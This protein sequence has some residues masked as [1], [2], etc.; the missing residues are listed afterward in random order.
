MA[1]S[2]KENIDASL[3]AFCSLTQRPE[4]FI[5]VQK[6]AA[7]KFT[8]TL[9]N[10]YD[11]TK[12]TEASSVTSADTLPELIVKDFDDEQIWQQLELQNDLS[13]SN[14]VTGVAKLLADKK[15]CSFHQKAKRIK[16]DVKIDKAGDNKVKIGKRTGKRIEEVIDNDDLNG[17]DSSSEVENA[18]GVSD[19]ADEEISKL[20]SHIDNDV[21]DDDKFFD[22]TGD[23]DD[24]LNFDFGPLGQGGVDDDDDYGDSKDE[25]DL[26]SR[27]SEIDDLNSTRLLKSNKSVRF[28]DVD[29]DNSALG[30]SGSKTGDDT[31]RTKSKKKNKVKEQSKKG[32]IVD[33]AFFKL[34][35][36]EA[37][38]DQ[39]DKK[40]ERRQRKNKSGRDE[41]SESDDSEDEDIDVLTEIGRAHV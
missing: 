27:G 7:K 24:D 12:N 37:F 21:D 9:K 34:A 11:S 35:D 36:L 2:I 41:E 28:K 17:T 31:Q 13:I 16:E 4:D 5:T 15:I 18:E 3:E 1:A 39:E 20:R 26:Y 33:D 32:S 10:I 19:S 6:N 14:L 8:K 29:T 23:S 40:E 30:I 25:P 38:L 22:F